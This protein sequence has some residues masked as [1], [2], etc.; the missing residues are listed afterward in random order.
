MAQIL[1]LRKTCCGTGLRESKNLTFEVFIRLEVEP[2]LQFG[3][4]DEGVE[5]KGRNTGSRSSETFPYLSKERLPLQIGQTKPLI[6]GIC[7][8]E[9]ASKPN[10]DWTFTE[11]A[12]IEYRYC[13][14][15]SGC[16]GLRLDGRD[17]RVF[18]RPFGTQIANLHGTGTDGWSRLTGTRSRPFDGNGRVL[19]EGSIIVLK[20]DFFGSQSVQM[21][22]NRQKM[23]PKS[24]I[25]ARTSSTINTRLPHVIVGK[26]RQV[27]RSETL[28][29]VPRPVENGRNGRDGRHPS[30]LATPS[31]TE[32]T[33]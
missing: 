3:K 7:R 29:D 33:G 31:T 1:Y 27:P 25:G 5:E 14:F 24:P 28:L 10:G 9:S 8:Q 12:M 15:S 17:G 19:A 22:G 11:I 13:A 20:L 21:S 16:G 4:E 32:R 18:T 6:G 23:R 26:W 30:V 2:A